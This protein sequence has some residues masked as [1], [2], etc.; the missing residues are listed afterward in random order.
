MSPRILKQTKCVLDDTVQIFSFIICLSFFFF[1]L[2]L[3]IRHPI[4]GDYAVLT[5]MKNSFHNCRA[6]AN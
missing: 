2:V 6:R 3:E 4:G 5:S 1:C